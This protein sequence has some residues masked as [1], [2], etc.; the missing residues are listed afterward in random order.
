MTITKVEAEKI[1]RDYV[2]AKEAGAGCGLV[3]LDES[4][5]ERDFGWVFFYN[6][7]DYLETGEIRHTLAGNAP[8]VVTRADGAVHVTGTALPL[9]RYLEKFTRAPPGR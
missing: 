5:M 2:K 3:L 6:S 1:A 8:I 4:T 7:K 9:E